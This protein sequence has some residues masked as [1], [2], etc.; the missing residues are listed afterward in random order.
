[1]VRQSE[2]TP[3]RVT[4]PDGRYEGLPWPD[5]VAPLSNPAPVD[6]ARR[7]LSRY[8]TADEVA[9]VAVYIRSR[10]HYQVSKLGRAGAYVQRRRP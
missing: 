4:T 1:M 10:S 8:L 7:D 2:H 9:T 6:E 5:R 3:D